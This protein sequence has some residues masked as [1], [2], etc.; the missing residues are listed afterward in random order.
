MEK[1]IA[2]NKGEKMDKD[3]ETQNRNNIEYSRELFMLRRAIELVSQAQCSLRDA[4]EHREYLWQ[5]R[6]N[7]VVMLRA[8]IAI[9]DMH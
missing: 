3:L 5:H 6:S 7:A 4:S 9:L 2:F 1:F 8:A